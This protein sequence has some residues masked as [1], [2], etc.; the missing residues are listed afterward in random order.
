MYTQVKEEQV[1]NR[2]LTLIVK[3]QIK[4]Q[5]PH[6]YTVGCLKGSIPKNGCQ[7]KQTH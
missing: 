3:L 1:S 7:D 5:W 4:E 2:T 6:N